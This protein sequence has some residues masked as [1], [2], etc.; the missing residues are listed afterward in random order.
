MNFE[1]EYILQ[2]IDDIT[3]EG[4]GKKYDDSGND[5]KVTSYLLEELS[6]FDKV[7]IRL[8]LSGLK[9]KKLISN[10]PYFTGANSGWFATP[11]GHATINYIKNLR[12][13]K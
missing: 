7:K 5:Y 12:C 8:I 1:I 10:S 9:S 13:K 11:R 3:W 6:G 2:I 4:T